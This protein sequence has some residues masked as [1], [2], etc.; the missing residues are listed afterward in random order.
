MCY[1]IK[2]FGFIKF[3]FGYVECID[4]GIVVHINN[5]RA[6]LIFY[7]DI[8]SMRKKFKPLKDYHIFRLN[9]DIS[10][11]FLDDEV[12][13]INFAII[14]NIIFN[15]LAQFFTQIKPYLRLNSNLS[16]YE[17]ENILRLKIKISFVFNI[18]M[19]IFSL[20]KIVLE[21]VVYAIKL[22]SQSNK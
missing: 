10:I 20:I 1:K 16:L 8:F 17:Q 21:K 19:A 3:L 11:G 4:E 7:K 13:K 9:A 15:E 5:K 18:L 14:Y 6:I 12:Q 22:K 2:L